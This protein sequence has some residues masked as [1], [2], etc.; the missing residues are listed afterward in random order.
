MPRRDVTPA[1]E[2][3]KPKPKEG[4][5][6]I[7]EVPG[8]DNPHYKHWKQGLFSAAFCLWPLRMPTE[9]RWC[10]LSHPSAVC[11]ENTHLG[12]APAG[13]VEGTVSGT[14]VGWVGCCHVT[15]PVAWSEGERD[16]EKRDARKA[17]SWWGR[18][19]VGVLVGGLGC[20]TE[21][22]PHNSWWFRVCLWSRGG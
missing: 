21:L 22:R 4:E 3:G 18:G 14:D 1:L 20:L 7:S 6:F 17:A 8:S 5:S 9:D 13:L 15:S 2:S 19:E 16:A 11:Q 12:E 10:L